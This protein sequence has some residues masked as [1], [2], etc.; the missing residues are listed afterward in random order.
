MPRPRCLPFPSLQ[1]CSASQR[2]T[3]DFNGPGIQG[4]M[5]L[6]TASLL[7]TIKRSHLSHLPAIDCIYTHFSRLPIDLFAP[8]YLASQQLK[9]PITIS[10][11]SSVRM[12]VSTLPILTC[13]DARLCKICDHRQYDYDCGHRTTGEIVRC[14]GV[15]NQTGC[16]GIRMPCFGAANGNCPACNYPTPPSS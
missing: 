8:H 13:T 1:G 4:N 11:L 5:H 6:R 10:P 16:T 12:C 14:Q 7:P 2:S 3:G 15:I 9:A